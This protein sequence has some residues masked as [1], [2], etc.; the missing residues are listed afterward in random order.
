MKLEDQEM[1]DCKH[2]TAQLQPMG[3]RGRGRLIVNADDWGRNAA[4]TDRTLDCLLHGSL[5]SVSAMVFMA[6]SER[7]VDLAK[8]HSID[9]GLHLNFTT[10]FDSAHCP[11]RLKEHQERLGRFLLLQRYTRVLF[12]PTL[13]GSFEYVVASQFEEYERLYGHAPLR[14]DGHHHMHLCANVLYG[15]LLPAGIIARRNL[16]FRCGEQG[17]VDH[18]YRRW[19]DY[20]LSQR[21]R[22]TDYFYRIPPVEPRSRMAEIFA[23]AV[24]YSVELETHPVDDEDYEFLM[25]GGLA[26]CLGDLEVARGYSLPCAATGL[27]QGAS[28]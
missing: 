25:E 22:M 8:Q 16:S 12:M 4:T 20:V 11:P 21:H 18:A 10:P 15:K 1:S 24:D 2:S 3:P 27:E 19:L 5:S 7:S 23:N 14:V 28:V 26:S 17:L 9:A 6:D 13:A